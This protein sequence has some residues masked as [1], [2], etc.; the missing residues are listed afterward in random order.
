VLAKFPDEGHILS[1]GT[2]NARPDIQS[3]RNNDN[4]RHDCARYSENISEGRHDEEWLQQ[5]WVAHEKHRRGDF[6]DYLEQK[7]V[8]DWSTEIPEECR[9]RRARQSI[10]SAASGSRRVSTTASIASRGS[11]SRAGSPV[12]KTT[13]ENVRTL[14]NLTLENSPLPSEAGSP[15]DLSPN[16]GTSMEGVILSPSREM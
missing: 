1:P 13:P 7:F 6:D 9:M 8:E 5:A 10:D 11:G 3:L 2:D 15:R 12:T 14:R 16:V 4:F